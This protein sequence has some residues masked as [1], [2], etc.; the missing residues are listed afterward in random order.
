MLVLRD[1]PLR[2]FADFA[3][4][5]IANGVTPFVMASTS[6]FVT[7][8]YAI[9]VCIEGSDAALRSSLAVANTWTAQLRI[10]VSTGWTTDRAAVLAHAAGLCS[11]ASSE[12][13]NPADMRGHLTAAR[14]QT[15][16]AS[17][18]PLVPNVAPWLDDQFS[19]HESLSPPTCSVDDPPLARSTEH[20]SH[21]MPTNE[22]NAS[23]VMSPSWLQ[24]SRC[25]V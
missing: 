6:R 24:C 1:V 23:S 22:P 15:C 12:D 16:A 7:R 19:S 3:E 17:E 9:L 5:Y 11:W 2:D 4:S 10:C 14:A 18:P 25:L 8:R 13:A 21:A 20:M